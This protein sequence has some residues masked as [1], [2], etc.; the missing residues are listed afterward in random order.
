[1]PLFGFPANAGLSTEQFWGVILCC[2]GSKKGLLQ[3]QQREFP[4]T[5][6]QN[7]VLNSIPLESLWPG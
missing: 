1:M 2:D 3:T 6:A 4:L 7:T 5:T